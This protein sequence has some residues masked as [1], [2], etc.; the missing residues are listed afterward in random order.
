MSKTM[1]NAADLISFGLDGSVV[2]ASPKLCLEVIGDSYQHAMSLLA[3]FLM[4]KRI[5]RAEK[6]GRQPT[7]R[8]PV[9]LML[10]PI[11]RTVPKKLSNGGYLPSRRF[12]SESAV[13]EDLVLRFYASQHPVSEDCIETDTPVKELS[14][15]R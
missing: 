3:A 1:R 5:K 15:C 10:S 12:M 11:T 6:R 13:V 8:K 7:N 4:A 2:V 14:K 9:H